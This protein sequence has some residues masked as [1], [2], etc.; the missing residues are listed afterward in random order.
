MK[1]LIATLVFI[2]TVGIQFKVA[3]NEPTNSAS[4]SAPHETSKDSKA[5]EI[6]T[7][8]KTENCAPGSATSSANHSTKKNKH[9]A[10]SEEKHEQNSSHHNA[11]SEKMNSLFPQKSKNADL[12]SSPSSVTLNSP[13][14][15]AEIKGSST[16][17]QWKEVSGATQYHVQVATDPNFKWLVTNNHFVK[18]NSLEITELESGKNYYWRVA[19]VNS[20]N[21]SMFT[22]SLFTSS[23]FITK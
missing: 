14:F 10:S 17:L 23:V 15:L 16:K 7:T 11:L 12:S 6:C 2:L 5:P 20:Q 9:E 3:A 18:T 22:K 19:S 8:E 21:D 1:F 4:H 13:A